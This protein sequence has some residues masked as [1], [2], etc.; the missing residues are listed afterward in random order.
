VTTIR[1]FVAAALCTAVAAGG[2]IACS[3]DATN[4]ATGTSGSEVPAK[5]AT[6]PDRLVIRIWAGDEQKVYADTA[7][8]AFTKDTGI[9]IVWDTT[10]EAVSYAKLNQE[11]GSGQPPS[12]DASFNAQQRAYTNAA[13]GWTIPI[14][15]ELAPNMAKVT[16]DVAR[17][18]DSTGAAWSYLN[19][20]TLSVPFIVRTDKVDP[21]QIQSWADLFKPDLSQ[22]V[23]IDSIYS[24]TA[25]GFAQSLGVDPASNPPDGMAPVWS[26]IAEIKPNL[27]QLGS[28]SD[29]VTALTN[30][31]VKVAISNTGSGISAL[32]AGA[33]IKMVAPKDG[34]YVVGDSYYIHKG[35]PAATAYYAQVFANYILD[36]AV[37]SAVADKLGLVPVNPAAT[38]PAY[39]TAD[40]RVFP[41]SPADLKAVNAIVAPIPLMAKNDEAWQK[42]FDNAI[43]Q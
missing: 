28:N 29:V 30:G 22:S 40:P 15:P 35:I 11:I 7:G 37:Q 10:D 13:R 32:A 9:P 4:D 5:P 34:L 14:N 8:A 2:L 18:S 19:P 20:Y 17:P 41:R 38:V 1:R 36:P 25:F 23:A 24:S 39:M 12:V 33:P 26:R 31:S 3:S 27:A 43:G 16:A 21:N 42:A 6:K